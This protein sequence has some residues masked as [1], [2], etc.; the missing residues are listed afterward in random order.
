M[1]PAVKILE[2]FA[3]MPNHWARKRRPRFRRN[4]DWP[5]DEKFIVPLHVQ[6]LARKPQRRYAWE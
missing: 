5:R 1:N 3:A 2:I 6:K 4:L